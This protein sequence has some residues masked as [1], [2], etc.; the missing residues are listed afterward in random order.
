[1]KS[2]CFARLEE[3]AAAHLEMGAAK[4][5]IRFVEMAAVPECKIN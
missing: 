3:N 4:A 1:M 5:V 2:L